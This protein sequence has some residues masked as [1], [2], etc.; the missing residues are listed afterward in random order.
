MNVH[1][2]QCDNEIQEDTIISTFE[3]LEQYKK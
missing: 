2:I 1:I 3:E